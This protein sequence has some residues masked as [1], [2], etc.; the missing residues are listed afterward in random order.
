MRGITGRKAIILVS[1]GVDTFS[2]TS[3]EEVLRAARE[4][5]I[6]IYTIGLARMMQVEANLYGPAAPFAHIDWNAAENRLETLARSSGG[7]AYAPQS[8]V[9]VPA[10]YDDIMENLRVRYVITY[11]SS[12]PATSGLPRKIRV[13]LID[14]KTGQPLKFRD[15]NGKP[16][17]ARV[18]VQESY[19]PTAA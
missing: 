15:S 9:E 18:F 13:E 7:R 19:S 17:M 5:A 16:V 11:V 14:P 3:Y 12:N 8:E 4:A 2:K 1:T 6:P 10:I